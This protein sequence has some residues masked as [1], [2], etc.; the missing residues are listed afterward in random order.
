MLHTVQTQRIYS[1]NGQGR[2]KVGL[3]VETCRQNEQ[4]EWDQMSCFFMRV[5][6]GG[7]EEGR[8]KKIKEGGYGTKLRQRNCKGRELASIANWHRVE[9]VQS[10]PE[11]SLDVQY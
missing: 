2:Y 10:K 1:L 8:E 6:L 5:F 4:G 7:D 11:S 9:K 3:R